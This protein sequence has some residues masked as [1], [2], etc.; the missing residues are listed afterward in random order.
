MTDSDDEPEV[1]PDCGEVHDDDE[2]DDKVAQS[3]M[4]ADLTCQ[5]M[6]QFTRDGPTILAA[7]CNALGNV[8]VS[9]MIDDA[10]IDKVRARLLENVGRSFDGYISATSKGQSI[11]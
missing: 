7:L 5:L 6:T 2:H 4:L 3:L 11:Q 10:P 8:S 1:C 9:T